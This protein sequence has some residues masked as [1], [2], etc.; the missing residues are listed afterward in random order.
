MPTSSDNRSDE[1]D[2]LKRQS[3]EHEKRIAK[4]EQQLRELQ[5]QIKNLKRGF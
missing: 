2:K 1:L 4:L 5:M 3:A